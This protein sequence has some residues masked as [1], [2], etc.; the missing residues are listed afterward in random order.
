MTTKCCD[1]HLRLATDAAFK[2]SEAFVDRNQFYNSRP[3]VH[4]VLERRPNLGESIENLVHRT[5]RDRSGHDSRCQYD[6][7]K[8]VVGLQIQNTA[9]VE[10][11]VVEVDP[12]IVLAY[13]RKKI[14]QFG[15]RRASRIVL[16]QDEFFPISC[17]H[18]LIVKL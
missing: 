2:G 16:A 15:R 8:Y 18:T 4:K 17:F 13:G 11:H 5:K 6:V 12:K 7:G 3:R 14:D 9:D 1:G 10:V